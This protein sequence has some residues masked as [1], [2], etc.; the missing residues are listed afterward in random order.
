MEN[1][2]EDLEKLFPTYETTLPFCK[3]TVSF[4]PFKVKDA[5]TIA[6]ILQENNKKLAL[7]AM[8][9]LLKSNSK[10]V[11][12]YNL[13]L[14]DAEYLFLQIR[15]KSVDEVL[16]LIKD[17]EKIQLNISDIKTRNNCKKEKITIGNNIVVHLE[18][19]LIK[20]LLKMNSLEKEE[21][22]KASISQI[23]VKNEIYD[24]HK[25]VPEDIKNLLDNLPLSVMPA[26]DKFMREQP[27]LYATLPFNS[28]E[29]E[30]SGILNFF[31]YR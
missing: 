24:L 4:K 7:K 20:N 2:I 28:G 30:V 26:L 29:K 16:N 21:L 27:E 31:T 17:D 1:L 6:I 12:V 19:P 22:F 5:K 11:D 8:V 15:S 13:C 10:D 23:T 3:K 14:A 18:T 25:Y 9:D